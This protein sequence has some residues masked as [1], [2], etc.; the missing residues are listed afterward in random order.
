MCVCVFNTCILIYDISYI[1]VYHS[2]YLIYSYIILVRTDNPIYHIC[3]YV[4]IIRISIWASKNS[5]T[6]KSSILIG[7]SIINHP[8]WSTPVVG[9]THIFAMTR[10]FRAP[11]P[12]AGRLQAEQHQDDIEPLG[13]INHFGGA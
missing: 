2:V 3:I 13:V 8:F 9:N 5:G 6:L 7:F 1:H 10:C 11:S 12:L 4:Y